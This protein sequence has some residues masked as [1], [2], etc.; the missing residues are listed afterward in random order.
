[1]VHGVQTG[2]D[3]ERKFGVPY[4]GGVPL[5]KSSVTD[6][7]GRKPPEAYLVSKPFSAFAE[8]M[9]SLWTFMLRPGKD[10]KAPKVVAIVSALPGEGKSLTAFC[11]AR[12]MAMN[13]SKVVLVDCDIRRRGASSLAPKA[14]HG[15]IEV[16]TGAAT[17][18]QAL[19]KDDLTEAW[20]LRTNSAPETAHGLF[21]GA[22]IDKLIKDLSA[23]F[24]FVVLDTAP[25][26]AVAE[27]RDLAAK[28]DAVLFLGRWSRTPAKAM[29]LA[30]DLVLQSGANL[31]GVALTQIDLRKQSRYGYGDQ[32]SYFED[33]KKYYTS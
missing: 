24:D 33:Y 11:L 20:F 29:E 8:S 9:R 21:T 4:A 26:L 5:F 13:G 25:V 18:D 17:L 3:I 16:L 1:M 6:G 31:V 12:T 2:N 27:T 19:V 15:L 32:Y 14:E 7:G 22:K 10:A 28:A 30:L 23:Q